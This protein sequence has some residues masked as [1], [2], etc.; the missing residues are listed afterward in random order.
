M[1]SVGIRGRWSDVGGWIVRSHRQ[2]KR[3]SH[4]DAA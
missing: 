1:D 2:S 4:E 3:G